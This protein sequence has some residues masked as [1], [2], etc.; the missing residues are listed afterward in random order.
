MCLHTSVITSSNNSLTDFYEI[1]R[2]CFE[3]PDFKYGLCDISEICFGVL[4]GAG[5]QYLPEQLKHK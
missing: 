4:W 5:R 3:Q 2:E 1:Q